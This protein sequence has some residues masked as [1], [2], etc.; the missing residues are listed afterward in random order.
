[1]K[2]ARAFMVYTALSEQ[3]E[4]IVTNPAVE[5]MEQ[6]ETFDGRMQFDI[7]SKTE[8][9]VL[10]QVINNISDVS[11][12]SIDLLTEDFL[13]APKKPEEAESNDAAALH[14]QL[15]VTPTI[16]VDVEKLDHLMGLVGELVINQTRLV[17]V[18]GRF[19]E[20][21]IRHE[22]EFDVLNEVINQLSLVISELQDGMTQTRMLPIEQLFNRFPRLIR[23]TSMKANKEI[24][25][26]MIGK[27]TELDRIL[28][29]EISDPLIH[30]L[31]N[32]IDHGIEDQEIREKSGKPAKGKVTHVICRT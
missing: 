4:I 9:D 1:M 2:N 26:E 15:K 14:T 17:D 24:D 12:T 11:F 18:R 7:L 6:D 20:K 19:S 3:G 5:T 30:L 28:I 32:A 21:D 31:R 23:D 22:R 8:K 16:R 27:E 25:F 13:A 10:E 29:E